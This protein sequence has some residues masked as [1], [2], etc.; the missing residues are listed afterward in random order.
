MSKFIDAI[1]DYNTCTYY[2]LPIVKLNKFSF[3]NNNFVQ[4]YVSRDGSKVYVELKEVPEFVYS[5]EE[6]LGTTILPNGGLAVVF[7]LPPLLGDFQN[8][9]A[10]RFSKFSKPVKDAVLAYSG[11]PFHQM[12]RDNV[13]HTDARIMALDPDPAVRAKLRNALMSELGAV[14]PLD[15]ELISVPSEQNYVD[16]TIIIRTLSEGLTSGV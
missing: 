9:V 8:F 7:S 12:T 6:Y 15:Q 4:C 3:G 11:L 10:G 5:K 13:P 1:Y 14:I 2:V 16:D